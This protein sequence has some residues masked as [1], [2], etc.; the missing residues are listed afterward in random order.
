MVLRGLKTNIC[1]LVFN[2]S[3]SFLEERD[4][5]YIYIYIYIYILKG[6]RRGKNK[7]R[8]NTLSCTQSIIL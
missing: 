1:N 2:D 6:K 8:T 4:K 7:A 3:M 5:R